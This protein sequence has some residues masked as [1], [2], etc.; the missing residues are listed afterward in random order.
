MCFKDN[1][2]IV[3]KVVLFIKKLYLYK[4]I[5][6]FLFLVLLLF[7]CFPTADGKTCDDSS[8]IRINSC[9]FSYTRICI[10]HICFPSGI[11]ARKLTV[12]LQIINARATYLAD[13]GETDL[14]YQYYFK[15][16][17]ERCVWN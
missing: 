14:V 15:K 16:V 12:S 6:V 13:R 7:T 17:S 9:G 2:Q 10:R 11:R 1:M 4:R 5:W 3:C 8:I